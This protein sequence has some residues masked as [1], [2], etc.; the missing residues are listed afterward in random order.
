MTRTNTAIVSSLVLVFS[1]LSPIICFADDVPVLA[2][3][4]GIINELVGKKTTKW[5]K[6]ASSEGVGYYIDP[7]SIKRVGDVVYTRELVDESRSENGKA[8]SNI[9]IVAYDCANRTY[10]IFSSFEYSGRMGSGAQTGSKAESST[11]AKVI[12]GMV[13]EGAYNFACNFAPYVTAYN[14]FRKNVHNDVYMR[15]Y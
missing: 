15:Q 12:V 5:Q 2:A 10:K 4:R 3:D 13:S 11:H 6:Y 1:A 14:R 7:D 9:D 8:T